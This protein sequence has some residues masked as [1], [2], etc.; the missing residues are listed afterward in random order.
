MK[1]IKIGLTKANAF[2]SAKCTL[3]AF[4]ILWSYHYFSYT[5]HLSESWLLYR[6]CGYMLFRYLV[7]V[8]KSGFILLVFVAVSGMLKQN[9]ATNTLSSLEITYNIAKFRLG[10]WLTCQFV[11][12]KVY[13]NNAIL[14]RFQDFWKEKLL[15]ASCIKA[16]LDAS[17]G[18][19]PQG[20]I[21]GCCVTKT[22]CAIARNQ[23]SQNTFVL[24][25]SAI[26]S[27]ELLH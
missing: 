9:T 2:L 15:S 4:L 26:V 25:L 5:K 24:S 10:I 19:I 20:C 13:G 12:I 3:Q 16:V 21:K 7:Y 14:L 18:L 27:H 8:I 22:H 17:A 11:S 23:I 6:A 1:I